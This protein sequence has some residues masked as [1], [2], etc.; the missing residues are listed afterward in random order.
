M[1][2]DVVDIDYE[3]AND[4]FKTESRPVKSF[5]KDR[6]YFTPYIPGSTLKGAL[7]TA[8]LDYKVEQFKDQPTI[9]N[10]IRK[11]KDTGCDKRLN[12]LY[13]QLETIIFCNENK[14][15]DDRLQYDAKKDILKALFADDLKP[16]NYKLKVIK[17]KNRP[18]KKDR[19]NTIPVVLETLIEGEF[20]GE[21]RI[22]EHLLKKDNSL[23]T[24]RYFQDE[25]L[26]ID[27]I[28]KALNNFYSKINDIEKN[29]FRANTPNYQDY[30][31][32]IGQHSGAGSK[33]LNDLKKVNIRQIKKC[34][35]YQLSVWIDQDENPLGWA[36]LNFRS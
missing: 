8:I 35:D 25:P 27:L 36:K 13:N 23:T 7:R 14:N 19:D 18:S 32:K 20:E 9:T 11:I 10:I 21:I 29:R 26:D 15:R 34:F 17:P 22:D 30:F 28:K 1:A 5:I 33:S 4:L 24:N 2:R 6:Y 16:D 12:G 3:V 31:I